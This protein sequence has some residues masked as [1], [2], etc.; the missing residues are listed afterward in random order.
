MVARTILEDDTMSDKENMS[1][2]RCNH[3]A[4]MDILDVNDT[5]ERPNTYS[6]WKE[7][8]YQF[9]QET[10]LHGLKYISMRDTFVLRRLVV[11]Y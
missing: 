10:T 7:E 9:A 5:N 2:V 3:L 1:F 6:Q 4:N 11:Y 8:C